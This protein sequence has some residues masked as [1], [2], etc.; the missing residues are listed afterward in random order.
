MISLNDLTL[1]E[2]ENEITGLGEPK[3]RAAQIF[4]WFSK[5]ISGFDEMSDLSKPL[6][7][8]L[9]ENYGIRAA[10]IEK[11]LSSAKDG[12]DKYLLRLGDGNIIESVAMKYKHGISVCLSTQVG[13]RMGCAFCASALGGSV[14]NLSPGEILGQAAALQRDLGER[15]SNIV[16]MGIGEPLD[17]YEN[18]IRFLKNVNN[19]LGMNIGYRHISLSTCGLVDR[20]YDLAKENMPITLSVSL[21][22]PN[23]EIRSK[24]MPINKKYPVAKLI[25]A[26][27]EYTRITNR[28]ISFE[29][30]LIDGVND[31]ETQAGEL[32]ESLLGMLCH[33]NLIPANPVTESG[34]KKSPPKRVEAFKNRLLR[35]RINVTV[36]RALGTDIDASCGQLRRKHKNAQ[37]QQGWC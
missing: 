20:I 19:P 1:S 5:G 27:R 18:V 13:C 36:R 34:L 17:N 16:L 12:T 24:L 30:I 35:H 26:C 14:R 2:L 21:H 23:D 3:F 28:R 15:I 25:A 37:Q 32:S 7:Q 9:S 4:S 22:A 10:V 6:R 8:R 31:G 29:Y 33:V 11:K